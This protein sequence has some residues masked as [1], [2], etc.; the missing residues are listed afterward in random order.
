[1][2][3]IH[4]TILGIT[5]ILIA[6]SDYK[7]STW[8]RGKVQILDEKTLSRLHTAVFVGLFLMIATGF[9]M[10]LEAKDYY[11]SDSP[12]IVKM[13]FVLALVINGFFIGSL[14][15]VATTTPYS[16]LTPSQKNNLIISGSVST[17]GWIGAITCGL[18]L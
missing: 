12:F 1:M 7:G 16:A 14:S 10:F 5:L 4:L 6:I 8:M 18:L 3:T 9:S 17:I 13:V 2:T 11:L 15:K